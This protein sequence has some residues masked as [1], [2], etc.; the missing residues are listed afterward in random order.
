MLLQPPNSTFALDP[1]VLRPDQ[2]VAAPQPARRRRRKGAARRWARDL[3]S[4]APVVAI[5]AQV[6]L[7]ILTI[8]TVE[9]LTTPDYWPTTSISSTS[10]TRAA[11]PG[12][13]GG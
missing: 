2:V 3:R 4:V 13:T 6:A 7:L 10:N 9:K 11:P 1:L 12:I 8:V 5:A